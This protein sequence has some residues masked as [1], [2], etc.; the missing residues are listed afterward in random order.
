[1]WYAGG[2]ELHEI[3]LAVATQ[4]S[5][6]NDLHLVKYMRAVLDMGSF[7]PEHTRLYFA[8]ADCLCALWI[9]ASNLALRT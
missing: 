9:E 3:R 1:M 6:R 7:D 8:A 5:I 4:A 2:S